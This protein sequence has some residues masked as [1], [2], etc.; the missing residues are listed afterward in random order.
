MAA[1]LALP[2]GEVHL[3]YALE[4][5]LTDPTLL[6][7]YRAL[8]APEE[9]KRRVR[10]HFEKNRHEFLVTRALVRS[11]LSRYEAVPPAAWTFKQNA[12]GRP[13]I[14]G[15]AGAALR[16]NLTNTRGLV[17]CLVAR[18]R[19]IGVDVEDVGREGET[20]AIADRFFSPSEVEELKAQP[21]DRQRARFFDYWTLKEAYIK[22]RGMGLALPLDQFSYE[23]PREAGG[24]IGIAFDPRLGDDP[25]S[26]QFGQ[27]R[28][29]ASHLVSWAIRRRSEPDLR[30][31]IRRVV[32]LLPGSDAIEAI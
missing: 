19:E 14:A 20:V 32:P 12:H 27:H 6:A 1:L 28:P 30:V 22:A 23:L 2:D 4:D 21:A 25:A 26:W 31:V 10:F 11:T 5:R 15:P 3:H 13:E 29:T 17:A 9:E 16:F 18:D 7:A 8:L 24:P